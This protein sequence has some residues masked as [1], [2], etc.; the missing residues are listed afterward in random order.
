MQPTTTPYLLVGA[1]AALIVWIR[2]TTEGR[3]SGQIVRCCRK[4]A[5][6]QQSYK[7]KL[8][9]VDAME[10]CKNGLDDLT[11]VGGVDVSFIKGDPVNACACLTVLSFPRLDIVYRKCK[12]IR[13]KEPYVPG[14]LAFRECDHLITLLNDLRCGEFKHF[15]PQVIMVD[16]NGILHPRGLGLA[17]QFGVLA[18]IATV[19]VAKNLLA[20]DGLNKLAVKEAVKIHMSEGPRADAFDMPLIGQSGTL[21]GR[22]MCCAKGTTKPIYVSIGHR[23]SLTTA[24]RLVRAC[25]KHRIPEPVRQAD[26]ISRGFLRG[27]KVT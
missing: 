10:G 22:A 27:L 24:S 13:L 1:V 5:A 16:G 7:S 4:W 23:I 3:R 12:M 26:L 9:L 17:S 2:R 6:L 19:G 11:L 18:G 25:C 8:V 14:F 15:T 21:W 20:V